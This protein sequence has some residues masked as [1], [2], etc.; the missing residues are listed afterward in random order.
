[1]SR[2]RTRSAS[3]DSSRASGR[4]RRVLVGLALWSACAVEAAAAATAWTLTLPDSV[5]VGGATVRVADLVVEPVP[6][7][8]GAVL[9]AAGGRPGTVLEVTARAILRRLAMS[10]QADGLTLAGAER[11][12]LIFAGRA[13]PPQELR[14][15]LHDLLL[16]HV[17]P[18]MDQAPPSWLELELPTHTLTVGAE[19]Q[20]SWPQ[21]RELMP[22]RNLLTVVVETGPT[23]QRLAVA[24][25]LHAFGRV[26]VPTTALIRGQPADPEAMAWQWT[27][28]A[29]AAPGLVT[30]PRALQNMQLARDLPQGAVVARGDLTPQPLVRRGEMV[31]LVMR[32]RGV[33]AVVRVE[34]RQDGFLNQTISVRN[35]LNGR[36]VVAQVAA[37][38]VVI[39]GR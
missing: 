1:M 2:I 8:A 39:T 11:C 29:L 31:D 37:A 34:S 36:L 28:L 23:S 4:R 9:V 5:V 25:T 16:P 27:D 7:A 14:D 12:R 3:G 10:G 6:A 38:G 20:L 22:G 26:A 24:A 13:V 32:R 19:W 18:A 21:P 15:R 33:E 17:P 30:D 35:P